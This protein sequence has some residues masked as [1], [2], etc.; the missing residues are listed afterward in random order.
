MNVGGS[1]GEE[2][3]G[4]QDSRPG[5]GETE[6]GGESHWNQVYRSRKHDEL[7]WYQETPAAS[8]ALLEECGVDPSHGVIDVGGGAS[9]FTKALLARGFRDLTVLDIS[10]V[11]LEAQRELLG[12]EGSEVALLRAD[13]TE[14]LP[15]RRWD[16]WHDRAVFHF[17][18]GEERREGYR[19]VLEGS[20]QEGA[21]AVIATFALDGPER[22]SGLSV[23]RYDPTG[24]LEALGPRFQLVRHLEEKHVTPHGGTQSFV[25]TVLRYR[26]R[27]GGARGG[28]V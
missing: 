13:V 3:I 22:C 14:F 8:L 16:L 1:R 11:A 17:L 18:T 24:L 2:D 23:Q 12:P 4:T 7:S 10:A 26:G 28:G 15:A 25:Y 20:L 21:H 27:A 19:K 9:R 6:R 5:A